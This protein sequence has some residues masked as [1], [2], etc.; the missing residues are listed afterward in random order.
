MSGTWELLALGLGLVNLTF[1]FTVKYNEAID[2]VFGLF[3]CV[4]VVE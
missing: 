2:I 1:S 4:V 3:Y